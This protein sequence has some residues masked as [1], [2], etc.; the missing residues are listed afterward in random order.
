MQ[1]RPLLVVTLWSQDSTYFSALEICGH[2]HSDSPWLQDHPHSKSTWDHSEVFDWLR[3]DAPYSGGA[4]AGD[5]QGAGGKRTGA[6][7]SIDGGR[8]VG[9]GDRPSAAEGSVDG[10]ASR[11]RCM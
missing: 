6:W 10:E 11:A 5:G 7:P 9:C 3:H 4:R 2:H 8:G 1:A